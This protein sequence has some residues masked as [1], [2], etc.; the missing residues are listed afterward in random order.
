MDKKGVI[1]KKINKERKKKKSKNKGRK[2]LK[3]EKV[4][5]PNFFKIFFWVV[6]V[7]YSWNWL[8]ILNWY[9]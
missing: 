5:S 1:L 6:Y 9:F 8:A 4:F 2:I 7:K 3:K